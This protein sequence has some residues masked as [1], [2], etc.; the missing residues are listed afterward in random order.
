MAAAALAVAAFLST[1]ETFQPVEHRFALEG[2]RGEVTV[3]QPAQEPLLLEFELGVQAADNGEAGVA[4]R[5][6]GTPIARVTPDARYVFQRVRV[7]VPAVAVRGGPNQLEVESFGAADTRFEL[8]ARLHN[9][10]G[11]NPRFPRAYVV[12]DEAMWLRWTQHGVGATLVRLAAFFLASLVAILVFVR[13]LAILDIRVGVG[14]LL[15]PSLLLWSV[16]A[17]SL[18]TP[19]HVWLSL[20]A[21]LLAVLIPCVLVWVGSW[22][23]SRGALLVRLAVATAITLAATEVLFRV[24]NRLNPSFIFYSDAY[25]RFRPRPGARHFDTVLNSHGFNDIEYPTAK[26]PGGRRIVAIGDS[27]TSG[28]VPYAANYLTLLERELAGLRPT[29]VINMGIPGTGPKDYLSILVAEGL[30]AAPDIVLVGFYIGNDFEVGARKPLE[31]S[32]VA[33]FFNFLWQLRFVDT[34]SNAGL[35]EVSADYDDERP[36]FSRERFLEVEADRAAIFMNDNVAFAT[37]VSRAVGYLRE[38]RDVA[39]RAG[40]SLLVVFMPAEVQVDAALQSDVI[41]ARQS[42]RERFDFERPNR[43]LAAALTEAGLPFVDLLPVFAEQA[44][45]TRLYKLQDTHWNIAGN[46]VA[47]AALAAELRR[48]N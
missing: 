36:G 9:Y 6:N 24:Y 37:A 8:R 34:P 43:L 31:Y 33:T 2:H 19:L 22:A 1:H 45:S 20:E 44:A 39:G 11:I 12:S 7:P 26:P 23:R 38:M 28:V 4:L 3:A 41:R 17:Y 47:A 21:A 32:Y 40:A 29:E 18:S 16:V 42:L 48:L 14:V 46:R 15:A 25:D 30:A 13:S 27:F 10:F 35:R 5:F